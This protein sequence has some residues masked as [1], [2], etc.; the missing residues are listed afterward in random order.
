MPMNATRYEYASP[1]QA[2]GLAKDFTSKIEISQSTGG[3]T[4]VL[5]VVSVPLETAADATKKLREE[6]QRLIDQLGA[7]GTSK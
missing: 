4:A 7:M 5:H 3:W 6:M 1:V 2:A